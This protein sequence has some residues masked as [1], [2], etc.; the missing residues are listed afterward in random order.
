MLVSIWMQQPWVMKMSYGSGGADRMR[1]AWWVIRLFPSRLSLRGTLAAA[2]WPQTVSA[3]KCHYVQMTVLKLSTDYGC[4]TWNSEW[5]TQHHQND[6]WVAMHCL[7][8][9]ELCGL[10]FPRASISIWN[11]KVQ[12][13]LSFLWD[14]V[15]P[16][17]CWL[18]C[19]AMIIDEH[20]LFP[21]W[22]CPGNYRNMICLPAVIMKNPKT[23]EYR[24]LEWK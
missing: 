14:E 1:R 4:D 22:L 15:I 12:L 13:S 8:E 6:Q 17:E 21:S 11:S 20:L 18:G 24:Y 10:G 23:T 16:A 2:N 19:L 9:V 5:D 3:L 7:D